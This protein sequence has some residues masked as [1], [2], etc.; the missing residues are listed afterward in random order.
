MLSCWQKH[1]YINWKL[2]FSKIQPI[3]FILNT[4]NIEMFG[5]I[6]LLSSPF[7]RC[8]Y[9]SRENVNISI[10]CSKITWFRWRCISNNLKYWIYSSGL[11]ARGRNFD[12]LRKFVT[13]HYTASFLLKSTSEKFLHNGWALIN[14]IAFFEMI[15]FFDLEWP[16]SVINPNISNAIHTCIWGTS[17]ALF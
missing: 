10:F 17:F 13:L 7:F 1:T 9:L 2:C 14:V 12:E 6:L 11:E 3:F 8:N 15:K 16:F 5:H 4:F